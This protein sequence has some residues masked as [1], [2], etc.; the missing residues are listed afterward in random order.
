METPRNTKKYNPRE[1]GIEE[2]VT[3][4]EN[5][6]L[7]IDDGTIIRLPAGTTLAAIGYNVH[8]DIVRLEINATKGLELIIHHNLAEQIEIED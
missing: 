6:Q 1:A 4:A 7:Q 2:Q 3:V 8:T 5:I